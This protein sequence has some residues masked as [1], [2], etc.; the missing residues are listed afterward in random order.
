[1][2]G[3][4]TALSVLLLFERSVERRAEECGGSSEGASEG[5]G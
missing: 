4:L 3:G 1:M 2:N 5:E